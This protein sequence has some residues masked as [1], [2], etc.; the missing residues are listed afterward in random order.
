MN[1]RMGVPE[2]LVLT[3]IIIYDGKKS[4]NEL[5]NDLKA[6][7]FSVYDSITK[8]AKNQICEISCR[9][10]HVLFKRNEF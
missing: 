8:T 4:G 2:V 10:P 1:N 3:V 5:F 9:W 7:P 6:L